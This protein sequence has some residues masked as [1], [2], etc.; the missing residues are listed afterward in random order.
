M[1][2]GKVFDLFF[3]AGVVWLRDETADDFVE[4]MRSV[5]DDAQV[6]DADS[7][8]DWDVFDAALMNAVLA[9][10]ASRQRARSLST[11]VL[12]RL[13]ATT[14]IREAIAKVGLKPGSMRAV[15]LV[16]G[17]SREQ[18]EEKGAKVLSLAGGGETD[19]PKNPD[20]TRFEELY[21]VSE[22]VYKSVQAKTSIEALKLAI[23]QKIA[24]T[25]I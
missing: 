23:M 12:M 1:R 22:K 9:V 11:E 14:Q 3:A 10:K 6:F 20:Q 8:L 18:V 7:I 19:L 5:V 13:A 21:G 16:V 15:F 25:L 17:S 2:V 24:S 4:K